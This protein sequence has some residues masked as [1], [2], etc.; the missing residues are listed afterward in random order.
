MSDIWRSALGCLVV[1]GL[2]APVSAQTRHPAPSAE[3]VQQRV[4][5]GKERLGRKWTDEQRID[6]CNVPPDKRGAKPRPSVCPL[7]PSS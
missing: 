6:N 4:L 1:L 2:L 3:A 7:T 5:T